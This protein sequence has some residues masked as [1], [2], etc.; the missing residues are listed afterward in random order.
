MTAPKA[1]K[2]KLKEKQIHDT[3][4]TFTNAFRVGAWDR[5]HERPYSNPYRYGSQRYTDWEYGNELADSGDITKEEVGP[6]PDDRPRQ[7]P[8]RGARFRGR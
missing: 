8:P 3:L 6:D 5:W 4:Y 2:K 1:S 7:K